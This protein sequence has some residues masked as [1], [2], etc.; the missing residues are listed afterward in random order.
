MNHSQ[1][2]LNS[3]V[4]HE[5]Q[6]KIWQNILKTKQLS[7]AYLFS[8]PAH[9]GKTLIIQ[10]LSAYLLHTTKDEL[11][12]H[13]DFKLISDPKIIKIDSIRD[14]K[15]HLSLRAYHG[16]YKIAFVQE[17]EKMNRASLNSFLKILE[18]PKGKTIIFLTTNNF[19]S[20]LPTIISRCQ[21]FKFYPVAFEKIIQ[22]LV[23]LGASAEKA[24]LIANRSYGLPGKA[25]DY[26]SNPKAIQDEDYWLEYLLKIKDQNLAQCF[27]N[28]KTL[29]DQKEDLNKIIQLWISYFHNLILEKS[30]AMPCSGDNHANSYTY[31]DL[32]KKLNFLGSTIKAIQYN[33]NNRLALEVLLL[34]L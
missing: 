13:P 4:G 30:N 22:S 14:L 32:K 1:N 28:A 18:E 20:L 8:G 26:L 12:S 27:S 16:D 11:L 19:R 5:Q 23:I 7:H 29:I 6:I 9:L 25:F 34:N 3:I 21:I 17:I 24:R 2:I 31:L 10:L 15:H 33:A